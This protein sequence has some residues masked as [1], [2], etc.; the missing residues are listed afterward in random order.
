MVFSEIHDCEKCH[1]KIV[2]ITVDALGVTRCGYCGEVVNYKLME[3]TKNEH[4]IDYPTDCCRSDLGF[5]KDEGEG[6][7]S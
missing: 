7:F 3:V 5:D 4:S 1:G 6:L 2:A